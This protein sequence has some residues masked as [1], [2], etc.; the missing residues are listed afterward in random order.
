MRP[1][2]STHFA[3]SLCHACPQRQRCSKSRHGRS[4]KV[5][6][7]EAFYSELRHRQQSRQGR[8]HPR[9]RVIVERRLA[10]VGQTQGQRARYKG[11]RKNVFDLRRH[12]TVANIYRLAT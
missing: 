2:R 10:H 11:V 7:E 9:Q 8:A 3:A 12:A 6:R 5:Y 1:G 4:V